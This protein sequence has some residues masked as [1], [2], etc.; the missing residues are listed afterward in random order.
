TFVVVK[1]TSTSLVEAFEGTFTGTQK[2]GTLNI[3][4]SRTSGSWYGAARATGST[5]TNNFSGSISAAS[6]TG[7]GANNSTASGTLGTD[8]I[9]NGTFNDGSQTGTWSANRT[10]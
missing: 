5:A 3:I 9:S 7:T 1:E 4:L 2:S 10:M 6:L 8:V